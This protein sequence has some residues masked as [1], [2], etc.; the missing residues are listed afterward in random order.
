M[1]TAT[2][3]SDALLTLLLVAGAYATIRALEGGATGWLVL[4]G[5][6]VG[7]D[8]G[9][10]TATESPR[11]A[12]FLDVV[13]EDVWPWNDHNIQD[14]ADQETL[15]QIAWASRFPQRKVH[16]EK[17]RTVRCRPRKPLALR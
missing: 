11:V 10:R 7:C 15:G 12:R 8:R 4:A 2:T 6:C 1:V 14:E 3:P 13:R 5:A 17:P 9:A 16:R